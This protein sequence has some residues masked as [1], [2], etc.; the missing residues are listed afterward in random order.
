MSWLQSVPDKP[1]T[2]LLLGN[3]APKELISMIFKCYYSDG[4]YN[5][6]LFP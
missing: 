4:L 6:F 1:Q 2:F 3:S 5:D